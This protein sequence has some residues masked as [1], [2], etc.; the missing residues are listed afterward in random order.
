MSDHLLTVPG[1]TIGLSG[2]AVTITC[3]DPEV[4]KA[5]F[6]YITAKMVD[7]AYPDDRNE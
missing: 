4:A 6:V 2:N 3:D 7:D 5:M 1:A